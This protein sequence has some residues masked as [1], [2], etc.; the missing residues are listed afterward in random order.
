MTD[1]TPPTPPTPTPTPDPAPWYG[2]LE[3]PELKTWV[4]GKQF[5]SPQ[6]AL[7]SYM[8]AEKLIGAPPD[9]IIRLPKA[10][11]KDAW[12]GVWNRLGRPEKPEGYELPLPA[13]DDGA[14]SKKASEWFHA[15]GV[16][17]TAAQTIAQQWNDYVAGLVQQDEAAA[18]TKSEQDLAALKT[19]W[20]QEFDAKSEFGR[21]GLSAY[22]TKAGL[23]QDDLQS[24]ER[25]LGT[26]K[27]LKLFHEVGQ[28]TAE[29]GFAPGNTGSVSLSPMQARSKLNDLQKQRAEGKVTDRE[30][31]EQR[32]PLD[33][34][35]ARSP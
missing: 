3:Q 26:A 8:N 15:A 1:P 28:T 13:G 14:F 2:Q 30:Y 4:E 25:V 27:M 9:Q 12:N 31:W 19:E 21:R 20:G 34:V 35:L 22:G 16:P 10:E 33:T 23:T 18:R 17:K 6:A 24:L 7:S 11:D 5:A 29:H 32:Q